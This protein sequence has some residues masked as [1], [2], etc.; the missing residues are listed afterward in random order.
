MASVCE[1]RVTTRAA[2]VMGHTC[3]ET[4][5]ID[6]PALALPL[7][8]VVV[9]STL[10]LLKEVH[11]GVRAAARRVIACAPMATLGSL[12]SAFRELQGASTAFPTDVEANTHVRSWVVCCGRGWLRVQGVGPDRCAG[13]GAGVLGHRSAPA[14]V[15]SKP[16]ASLLLHSR[17][18]P[19]MVAA[20]T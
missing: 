2:A 10:P 19:V 13:G 9:A 20:V 5:G 3:G 1:S 18:S 7:S 17:R 14:T 11:D 16:P 8:D 6:S 15:H 12:V 4:T